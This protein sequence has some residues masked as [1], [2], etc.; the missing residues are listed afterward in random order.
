MPDMLRIAGLWRRGFARVLD[1]MLFCV[2]CIPLLL[3]LADGPLLAQ[4]LY[5]LIGMALAFAYLDP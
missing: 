1:H 4:A 3:L 2:V 5:I